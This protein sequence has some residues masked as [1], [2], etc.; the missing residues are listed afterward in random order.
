MITISKIE[1]QKKRADRYALFNGDE[2]LLGISE[3]TLLHFGLYAGMNL[4][5]E[6]LKEI[7][8]HEQDFKL[9]E[10]AVRLLA[11]RP[12]SRTELRI[13]LAQRGFTKERI[14]RVLDKL[15]TKNYID[16][17]AF[18]VALVTDEIRMKRSGPLLIM[19]KL[20]QKGIDGEAATAIIDEQYPEALQQENAR[21]LAEKKLK[22]LKRFPA[23][24]QKTKLAAYLQQKGYPWQITA[25]IIPNVITGE[26]DE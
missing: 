2:F 12:H 16:D 24:E 15:A 9:E 20:R 3:H 4:P 21:T 14:E 5:E 26:D 11:R 10:R 17:S 22:S 19:A 13:K 1:R 8:E 23:R 6:R 25:D 7:T 18:A